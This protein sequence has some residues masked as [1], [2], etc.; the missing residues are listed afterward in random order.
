[1][2]LE[3][4]IIKVC[5]YG[6]RPAPCGSCRMRVCVCVRYSDMMLYNTDI[7]PRLALVCGI[8][9]SGVYGIVSIVVF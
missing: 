7:T 5:T 1:M 9:F 6:S 8:L 4:D 3:L 2:R